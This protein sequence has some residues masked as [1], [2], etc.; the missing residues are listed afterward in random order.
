M[1]KLRLPVSEIR[2]MQLYALDV[3]NPQRHD[4]VTQRILHSYE[5]DHLTADA[6]GSLHEAE[7]L[8]LFS[9]EQID[10]IIEQALQNGSGKVDRA[11]I[12]DMLILQWVRTLKRISTLKEN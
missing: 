12:D 11:E 2:A 1:Q 5:K 4:L 6:F 3:Q 7:D 9:A 10:T 8:R